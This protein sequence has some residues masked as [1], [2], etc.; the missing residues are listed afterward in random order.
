M[1]SRSKITTPVGDLFLIAND[2]V[3]LAAG[4]SS[5]LNLQKR[6]DAADAK[7]Q[8]KEVKSI[9]KVSELISDYFDGDFSAIN[10]IEVRQPGTSFYQS[11]IGRAHV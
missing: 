11:K 2:S 1:L 3:L 8:F 10:A 6:L 5:Y 9:P 7:L 4:F